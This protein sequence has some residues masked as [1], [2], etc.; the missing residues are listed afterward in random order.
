MVVVIPPSLGIFVLCI[1]A[2]EV[3]KSNFRQYRQMKQQRWEESKQ[4]KEQERRSEKTKSQKKE[5]AQSK[6]WSYNA[7]NTSGSDHCWTWNCGKVHTA[8]ARSTFRSENVQSTTFSEHFWK[9]RCW[10]GAV[11]RSTLQSQNVQ[12]TPRLEHLWKE[13]EMLKK[14]MT[15]WHEASYEAK[16]RKTQKTCLDHFWWLRCRKNARR[17]GAKHICISMSKTLKRTVSDIFLKFWWGFAWQAQ[18]IVHLV[19]SEPNVWALQ[20]LRKR[21]QAWNVWRGCAKMIKDAFRMADAVQETSWSEKLVGQDVDFLRR[22]AFSPIKSSGL[23][24][25][26]CILRDR[27]STLHDMASLLHLLRGRRNTLHKWSRENAKRIAMRSSGLQ[28]A[29]HFWRISR[30]IAVQKLRKRRRNSLLWGLNIVNINFWGSLA[31][32]LRYGPVNL[33]F[34]R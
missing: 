1:H 2:K 13:V 6:F 11:A 32:L 31:E 14:C 3:L 24:R 7:E 28:S 12:S 9:L 23:L 33:H 27:C 8:V 21:W 26:F 34:R 16:T 19:K 22:V 15:L 17:C 10:K 29:I 18:W 5:R 20:H 25:W 4:R 30:T